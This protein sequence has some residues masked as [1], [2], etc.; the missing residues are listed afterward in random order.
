MPSLNDG[1]APNAAD[2]MVFGTNRSRLAVAMDYAHLPPDE[3]VTSGDPDAETPYYGVDNPYG[4]G[5]DAYEPNTVLF[6][7]GYRS[8]YNAVK[9][10]EASEASKAEGTA[11]VDFSEQTTLGD[12]T[13]KIGAAINAA[14]DLANRRVPYVWGGT[15]RNGVD[16]SGLIYYAFKS[17]GIDTKRYVAR[18]YA[19]MGQAVTIDQARPGDIVYFDNPGETDHVGIY[20]GNGKMVQAPQTGDVVRVTNIGRPTS[21]RRI[22]DDGSFN[23]VATPDGGTYWAYGETGAQSGAWASAPVTSAPIMRRYHDNRTA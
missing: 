6:D 19:N 8:A 21:I 15:S 10:T 18:D 11:N 3:W 4:A 16:C 9:A 2:G 17:A 5:L 22:F 14:L 7:G 13:G 1:P 12:A 23:E 20:L